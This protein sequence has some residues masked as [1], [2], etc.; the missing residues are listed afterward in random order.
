MCILEK[1]YE[2]SKLHVIVRITKYIKLTFKYEEIKSVYVI[3]I[4][5][6]IYV[7]NIYK[8]LLETEYIFLTR[9]KIK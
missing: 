5:S 7:Y 8:H 2:D 4:Y 1:D 6:I 3:Y 9:R